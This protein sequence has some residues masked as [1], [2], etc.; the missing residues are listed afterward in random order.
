MKNKP[1]YLLLT[2][3]AMLL[4]L[5]A[6]S[7]AGELEQIARENAPEIEETA[8]DGDASGWGDSLETIQTSPV[9]IGDFMHDTISD[10]VSAHNWEL[11][12]AEDEFVIVGVLAS[13]G[14]DPRLRVYDPNG[15]LIA[16]H[17][18]IDDLEGDYSAELNFRA[19]TAG[20]YTL[21]IDMWTPGDYVLSVR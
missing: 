6:C 2:A 1:T 21:R 5:I 18:D 15:E 17:D 11:T 8:K 3:S 16:E 19:P 10:D 12:L 4:V 9:A 7:S 20:A 14:S 13:G